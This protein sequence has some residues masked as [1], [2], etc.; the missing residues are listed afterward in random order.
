MMNTM[1]EGDPSQIAPI[2]IKRIK[3]GGHAAHHGGAWKVAYADFVTA[4]MAFFL[5]L[6][7]LATTTPEQKAGIAEYFTPTIGLK[8]S[9]GIGFQ[10]GLRP[11]EEGAS[12]TTLTAP[13]VVMGQVK[14]GPVADVPDN[15]VVHPNPEAE[16]TSTAEKKDDSTTEDSEEFKSA[17]DEAKQAIQQDEELKAYENNII[18][19]DTPEGLKIEMIDDQQKP[20]FV[21]GG[22][23]LT[24]M[25]KKVLDSMANIISK[26]PNNIAIFGHTDAAAATA[27]PQYGNWELSSD[28]ANASRRFLSSTQLEADRVQKVVGMADRQLLT[29]SE[30]TNPRNRRITITLMR[31][32]YFRDPNNAVPATRSLLSTPTAKK[33]E[34]PK[35]PKEVLL[36]TPPALPLP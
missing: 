16:S 28:R 27:N 33:Q 19:Q 7:L 17:Q 12:R 9:K 8:D 24:D 20:M 11:Q 35:P 29:P 2:I 10:G 21:P 6:W 26:T 25:G 23:V 5:L 18:M 22:A 1:A 31:G 14:Q 32:S 4:M 15:T 36:P 34:P 3:K 30:P 13:G